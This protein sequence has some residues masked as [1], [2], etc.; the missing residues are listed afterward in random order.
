MLLQLSKVKGS[1]GGLKVGIA[2]ISL[3]VIGFF[4]TAKCQ[5]RNTQTYIFR[6]S[7]QQQEIRNLG[8][9][10]VPAYAMIDKVRHN[11]LF[12]ATKPKT[13]L[14][15]SMGL[16]PGQVLLTID[17][18]QMSSA[19]I[20]DSWLSR[21]GNKPLNFTCAHPQ[22]GKPFIYSGQVQSAATE[23]TLV[24][25]SSPDQGSP[26]QK[27][28]QDELE[29]YC[30]QLINASRRQ[31]GVGPVQADA[32]LTQ[33]ARRYSDYMQAHREAYEPTVTR[34]PHTDL[35]GHT[36]AD[37]AAAAGFKV[38]T[39]ENI[40]RAS[41]GIFVS[42]KTVVYDL[43]SMMMAEPKGQI[44]HR[45]TIMD[46]QCRLVGVGIARSNDRFYLTEEFS[47]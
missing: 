17:G 12:I 2:L 23:Q 29:R 44:N 18:Y 36:T 41:R 4:Q 28:A 38:K 30:I 9:V 40:G 31:E 7:N 14:G 1:T 46:P 34:S 42:D 26:G 45:S 13:E 33:L 35:E 16:S 39:L 6:T 20:A 21:R 27:F 15:K 11:G 43:H 32:A 37:R 25:A 19:S 5:N 10:T 47:Y 24:Q 3:F 22:N 8:V